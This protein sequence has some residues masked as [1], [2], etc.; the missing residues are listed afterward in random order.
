MR[1]FNK[2]CQYVCSIHEIA[3]RPEFRILVQEPGQDDIEFRDIT[4]KAVW[5]HILESL[6]DLRRCNN[7]VQIFPRYM[8]GEE[9]F[10]LT[11]PAIVRILESLPGELLQ[12]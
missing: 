5:T 8:S 7:S 12:Q 6:A 9:L 1:I 10:G 11:E 3:G 4:P 2:R